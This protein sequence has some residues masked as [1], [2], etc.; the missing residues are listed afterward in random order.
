MNKNLLLT[1]GL[2]ITAASAGAQVLT[3]GFDSPQT[4]AET[5]PG[6]YEFINTLTGDEYADQDV[7]ELVAE[8]VNSGAGALHFYNGNNFDNS[9]DNSSWRRAVKFRNLQL[10]ENTSYR[11]SFYLCGSNT[12]ADADAKEQKSKAHFALMQGGENCDL[13]IVGANE[14]TFGNDISYFQEPETGYRKYTGMFFYANQEVQKAYYEAH[15]GKYDLE[16]KFFLALNVYNPGDYYIDDVVVEEA[17]I[18]SISCY[19]DIVRINFGYKTNI[20]DI[21]K[22]TGKK[23]LVLPTECMT[24][25]LNGAETPLLTV[26]ATD[27][28]EL[29]GFLDEDTFEED[30]EV[31]VSF[32]ATNLGF[33]LEYAGDLAP[34]AVGGSRAIKSF[35]AEKGHYDESIGDETFSSAYITPTLVSCDPE[36]GSFDLPEDFNTF[37]VKFDKVADA[38]QLEATLD[39]EALTVSPAEGFAEEFTLTRTGS[40]PLKGEKTLTVTKIFPERPLGDDVFGTA[41][42]TLN[43]GQAEAGGDAE[44]KLM[45]DEFGTYSDNKITDGYAK[46][47]PLGWHIW[48]DAKVADGEDRYW[49]VAHAGGGPRLFDGFSGDVVNGCALYLSGGYGEYG[50]DPAEGRANLPEEYADSTYTLTLVAGSKYELTAS[51]FAWKGQNYVKCSI[52]DPDGAEEYSELAQTTTNPNG[53]GNKGAVTTSQMQNFDITFKA[54]KTGNYVIRWTICNANGEQIGG[55][56]EVI[57]CNIKLMFMPSTA[58]VYE[59]NLLAV[60]L[61]N[62]KKCR[63]NN[64]GERFSG[65]A[66]TNLDNLIKEYDGKA[67]TAPSKY[68]AAAAAL[69][70]AVLAMNNH[71]A[72]C[73]QYDGLIVDG[74]PIVDDLTGEQTEQPCICKQ[75]INKWAGTKFENAD[76]YQ[77]L[78]AAVAEYSGRV[79]MLDDELAAAIAALNGNLIKCQKM[80]TQLTPGELSKTGDV[81]IGVAALTARQEYGARTIEA[82]K[83]DQAVADM[84]HNALTDDDNIS[85]CIKDQIRKTL[86]TDAQ[87][88]KELFKPDVT[89]DPESGAEIATYPTY[90]MSVFVKNPTFYTFDKNGR[91]VINTLNGENGNWLIEQGEGYEVAW[92]Y[93]WHVSV[94]DECPVADVMISNYN[95][96]FN[97]KQ[98]ITDLPAGVY[99]IYFAI[100]ERENEDGVMADNE[101]GKKQAWAYIQTSAMDE[102]D[103]LHV[104]KIGQSFPTFSSEAQTRKFEN[105]AITDGQLTIGAQAQGETHLFF[106]EVKLELT[107]YAEGFD[108]TNA[109][110]GVS[111]NTVANSI[112]AIESYDLSGRRVDSNTRGITIQKRTMSDGTVKA[113]KVVR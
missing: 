61:E 83:G 80:C 96:E 35:T 67:Y 79:L 105:V 2:A 89:V 3:E 49:G 12:Y 16:E 11:V 36:N 106:N 5:D 75:E 10:K 110:Q 53:E 7:R 108:Y 42:I 111:E 112:K 68:K 39:G 73:D 22:A 92:S 51:T 43:F 113:V 82:I 107:G 24:V 30:S 26:E 72:L 77:A 29:F 99:N 62:A 23:R 63:T 87:G 37:T 27:A 40:D 86:Y 18:E 47:M 34:G 31:E 88:A 25:K 41:T 1:L 104:S 94:T 4:K 98:Q 15:P 20:A 28:G 60:A 55:Y 44:P 9:L 8:P 97:V 81:T 66:W 33:D 90:D 59:K 32:D 70:A 45:W 57:L 17:N 38:A 46:A 109:I 102:A 56:S 74:E 48:S 85:T 101:T 91:D 76:Y 52:I 64:E 71:R 54:K 100:G 19:S 78:V 65:E 103:T 13:P 84:G 6:Y 58:G 69:D 95:R 14:A 50:L 93:G 21:V